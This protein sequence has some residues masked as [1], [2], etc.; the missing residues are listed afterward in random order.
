MDDDITNHGRA[1]RINKKKNY[2]N[3]RKTEEEEQQ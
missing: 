1:C 3:D 2:N